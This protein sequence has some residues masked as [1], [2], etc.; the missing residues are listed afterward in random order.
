MV[1]VTLAA[2]SQAITPVTPT[3]VVKPL[4]YVLAEYDVPLEQFRNTF[5]FTCESDVTLSTLSEATSTRYFTD[6]SACLVLTSTETTGEGVLIMKTQLNPAFSHVTINAASP[7]DGANVDLPPN[8]QLVVYDYVR[9]LSTQLFGSPFLISNISNVV[10]I[11]EDVAR[12]CRFQMA[13]IKDAL[14]A[15][16]VDSTTLNGGA[17]AANDK[18]YLT[19]AQSTDANICR[20]I[21]RAVLQQAP[22]RFIPAS[23]LSVPQPVPLIAGDSIKFK[24]TMDNTASAINGANTQT[25]ITADRVYYIQLNLVA[26]SEL[27]N[28]TVLSDLS[29]VLRPL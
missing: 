2:F 21:F 11:Q 7:K 13:V 28:T 27:N 26:S 18:R 29:T 6:A 23:D 20:E 15:V 3:V 5:K 16:H 1:Q 9:D 12:K 24:L 14:A 8:K 22:D 4:V 25:A 10:A 19:N 17:S